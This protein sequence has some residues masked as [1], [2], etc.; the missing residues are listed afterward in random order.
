[1]KVFV[2]HVNAHRRVSSAEEDFNNEAERMTHPVDASLLPQPAQSSPTWLMNEAAM[3]AGVKAMHR[4][5]N[6]HFHSPRPTWL[7][8]L[9]SAQPASSR[10][11]HLVVDTTPSR[12]D[13][14]A[15]LWYVDYTG[16][17]PSRKEYHFVLPRIDTYSGYRFAFLAHSASARTTIHGLAECLI[18]S[19]GIPH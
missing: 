11:Q 18:H 3:V 9:L 2:S 15:T 7:W 10:D 17:L 1:M 19:H 12:G 6:M 5:S 16:Q 14:L 13:L 8:P 4:L